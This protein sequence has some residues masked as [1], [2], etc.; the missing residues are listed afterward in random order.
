MLRDVFFYL[1][2]SL[3]FFDLKAKYLTPVVF[4]VSLG[5]YV[6]A[7]FVID[8]VGSSSQ[9]LELE[10]LIN[11]LVYLSVSIISFVYL[12]A[13]IYEAKNEAYTVKDCIR[14]TKQN[15]IMLLIIT[16]LKSPFYLAQ[17][18]AFFD[19][20][21]YVVWFSPVLFVL[22]LFFLFS[23]CIILDSGT[24]VVKSL[25]KSGRMTKGKRLRLLFIIL[26]SDIVILYAGFTL[27]GLFIESSNENI[28]LLSY[29][30][31]FILTI[32]SLMYYKRLAYLYVDVEYGKAEDQ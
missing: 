32:Y 12:S 11:L 9:R 25:I 20:F 29:A 14:Q 8:L 13:A 7:P 27:I 1:K 22:L 3:T 30:T 6:I 4:L 31:M 10:I 23:E 15:V 26:F 24:S 17:N 18:V 16:L 2:K 28:V 5:I 21:K 19:F